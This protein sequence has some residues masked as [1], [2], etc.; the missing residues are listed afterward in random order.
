[1]SAHFEVSAR[2]T[3]GELRPEW[4]SNLSSRQGLKTQPGIGL[5][6]NT[7]LSRTE[8]FFL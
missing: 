5:R 1:M 8:L 6:E 4:E 7:D 3:A 2:I